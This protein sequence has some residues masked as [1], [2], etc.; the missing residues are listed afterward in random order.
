M[1]KTCIDADLK[2]NAQS[3]G[4]TAAIRAFVF[5]PGFS[6]VMRFRFA[7]RWNGARGVRRA[8]SRLAWLSNARTFGCYLSP[9]AKIGAGLGLPHPVGIV[10]GDGCVLG[11]G[12]TIYQ[13]VTLGRQN[14]DTEAYPVI[15][16]AVTIYAGA[17]IVGNIKIGNG[18]TIA[19]NAV[20][21]CDVPEGALA[22]GIPARLSGRGI[23]QTD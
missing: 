9:K 1:T 8:V 14:A 18:A 7:H 5:N 20:V 4:F 6:V 10:I 12:V 11:N 15:G 17:V 22:V 2:V 3:A 21:N 16:D 23:R 13:N 19:A